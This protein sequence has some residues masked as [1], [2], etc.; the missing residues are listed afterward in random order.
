[1]PAACDITCDMLEKS[2]IKTHDFYFIWSNFK[3]LSSC[4]KKINSKTL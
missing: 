3:Y 4:G 2:Y 1:M